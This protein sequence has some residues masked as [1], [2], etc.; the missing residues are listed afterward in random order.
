MSCA[1]K[2]EDPDPALTLVRLQ[3]W[4]DKLVEIQGQLTVVYDMWG[5]KWPWTKAQ[6]HLHAA[7]IQT[8]MLLAEI[9]LEERF[10]EPML[11]NALKTP[12][13]LLK[14]VLVRMTRGSFRDA[15]HNVKN[16]VRVPRSA[17]PE[18][19]A[20]AAAIKKDLVKFDDHLDSVGLCITF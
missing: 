10:R 19:K 11:S 4:N 3:E 14:Y 6:Q 18:D 15:L 5:L 13:E 20:R 12:Y 2:Q 16:H 17:S 9:N 7:K 8:E 1:V